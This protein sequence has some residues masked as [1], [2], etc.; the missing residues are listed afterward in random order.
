MF[1]GWMFDPDGDQAAADST[2][3][4]TSLD[5]G[6]SLNP[7]TA[8]RLVTAS[9]TS[10]MIASLTAGHP[11]RSN[12]M[13]SVSFGPNPTS[14]QYSQTA[15]Y[16]TKDVAGYRHMADGRERQVSGHQRLAVLRQLPQKTDPDAGRLLG[17]VFEAV[18]PVGVLEPDLE[19][20]VASERQSIAAG[21]QADHAMPGG[22]AAGAL[23]D[24]PR[25]HL[26]LVLERPQLAVVLFQK[27][28]ARPPKRVRE[29]RRHGDAGEIGRLPEL[30]L[31]GRHVDPQVRTQPLFHPVGE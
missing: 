6:S 15:G 10:T 22:V 2:R 18:V 4:S 3:S 19:H 28:L 31:G 16:P 29:P 8:R 1:H 11:F 27:P 7:R 25:R 12:A 5:T 17:V 23:D 24:H 30:G 14:G 26:V 9:Y 13:R 21:R 20:G